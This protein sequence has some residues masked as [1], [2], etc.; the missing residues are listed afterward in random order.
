MFPDYDHFYFCFIPQAIFFQF[1]LE[2]FGIAKVWLVILIFEAIIQPG[3]FLLRKILNLGIANLIL[4]KDLELY[5]INQFYILLVKKKDEPTVFP[6]QVFLLL[7]V[8][9]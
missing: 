4:V 8:L 5:K 7:Q 2:S 9:N 1:L 3:F 6:V